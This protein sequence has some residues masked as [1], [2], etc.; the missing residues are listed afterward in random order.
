MGDPPFCQLQQHRHSH[1]WV[2]CCSPSPM[3]GSF[4]RCP[5]ASLIVSLIYQ[6]GFSEHPGKEADLRHRTVEPNPTGD[7]HQGDT[8]TLCP[9]CSLGAD[10]CSALQ[11]AQLTKPAPR[12]LQALPSSQS[13]E[14]CP[15]F[16]T[17]WPLT[18]RGPTCLRELR[19]RSLKP[20]VGLSGKSPHTTQDMRDSRYLPGPN[21]LGQGV[22]G[23]PDIAPLEKSWQ[24]H[25]LSTQVPA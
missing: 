7:G 25:L 13:A 14:L 12:F 21:A 17:Q 18:V 4:L 10:S 16:P 3:L 5:E 6:W 20:H 11:P 8:K 2:D 22:S 15:V 24:N 1:H 19:R 9:R 23:P